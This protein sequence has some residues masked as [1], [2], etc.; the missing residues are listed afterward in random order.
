MPGSTRHPS[1][2]STTSQQSRVRAGC[3]ARTRAAGC[4]GNLRSTRTLRP[5]AQN[6]LRFAS[7]LAKLRSNSCASQFTYT[8]LDTLRSRS[9]AGPQGRSTQAPLPR[10]PQPT[11]TRLCREVVGTPTNGCAACPIL[12]WPSD[13]PPCLFVCAP[14]VCAITSPDGGSRSPWATESKS[15]DGSFT[16]DSKCYPAVLCRALAAYR[17]VSPHANRRPRR[18]PNQGCGLFSRRLHRGSGL[19]GVVRAEHGRVDRL[20]DAS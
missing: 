11:R 4:A 6:S 3:G 2:L 9:R 20:H 16:R 12:A 15:W 7:A 13:C 1:L 18:E 17:H 8:R 14:N 5:S 10:A 19:S